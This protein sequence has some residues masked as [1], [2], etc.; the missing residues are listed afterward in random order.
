[1][2]IPSAAI[3]STLRCVGGFSHIVLSIAGAT[4]TGAGLAS[5]VAATTS[6]AAPRARRAMVLADAGA[7]TTRSWA[8]AS[9]TCCTPACSGSNRSVTTRSAVIAWKVSGWMNLRAPA[10]ITT[11]TRMPS[12]TSSLTR[13]AAL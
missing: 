3:R 7:T 9:S 10:D 5:T 1:M 13:A 2:V 4:S 12:C 8:V 11:R 6:S